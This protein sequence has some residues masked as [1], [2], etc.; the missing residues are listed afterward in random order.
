MTLIYFLVL[1]SVIIVI[2]EAGHLL[3]AKKF[4]VYC[5]EFS[6]GMGPLLWKKKTDE[7]QYSVRAIP[8]GGYVAMAGEQDGDEA[9]PD[10]QVPEG[11]RITDVA[12]W[13]KI[14]IMIAG[15]CM[16]FLL[17][18]VLFSM[19]ILSNGAFASSPKAIVSEIVAGS[20]AEKAGFA[21]GD[22]IKK[23]T[24]EDGSSVKPDTFLDMQVFS[25]G[26]DGVEIYEVERDGTRYEISVQPEYDEE[27]DSYLIGIVGNESTY[28][29]VNIL[30]CWYYGGVEMKEI[31][32]LML[33]TI[34]GLIFHGSGLQN[35]SGPVGIYQATETYAALG[36][37]SFLFLMAQI[38]LN[39]G[40]FNLLPL[41]VLD[42]GQIVFALA[43]GITGKAL[44]EKVK[45]YI[46]IACWVLL[47]GLMLFV[48]WNDITKLILK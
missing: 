26:Y 44:N 46:M 1:L 36:L 7:T 40:I 14:I 13:K 41:P 11:R 8:I 9:Y 17:A 43:E 37:K 38:S 23:V 30:N 45:Y 16:N 35:M 25:S 32:K 20:P 21:V 33:T 27:S 2:H 47:I 19:I 28:T 24:K 4:N 12:T 10:V 39:I 18:W 3:A 15:V 42:G 48:T 29:E 34:R 22:V 6:F 5:Y 31:T